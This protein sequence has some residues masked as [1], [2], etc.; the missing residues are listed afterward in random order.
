MVVTV[1]LSCLIVASTVPASQAE[2]S[3][4][5]EGKMLS[6]YKAAMARG[7]QVAALKR[8]LDY[9]E[10]AYGEN[11]PETARLTHRLGYALYQDGNYQEAAGVLK[12]ALERSTVAHGESGGEAFEINMNIAYASG[13]LS[14][15]L[16]P[17]IKYFDRA[18]EILRERGERD[19]ITYVTTLINI[20]VNLMESGSLGGSYSSSLS[21]TLQSPE[22][23]EY[24]LPIESEYRNNFGKPEKYLLEAVEIAEK[25]EEVDEYISSKI[26]ILQ[27][28]LKVMET[29]DLAAVPMGVGGY[30]SKAGLNPSYKRN[31]QKN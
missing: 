15:R 14:P 22:V 24:V 2:L 9:A 29:A 19:S 17:R 16:A 5:N 1:S 23:S 10:K 4:A 27:A 30:I 28:K 3:T 13:R 12:K 8:V 20:V 18:L 11:A 31:S 6:D 25:L 21:D 7:D 26:S